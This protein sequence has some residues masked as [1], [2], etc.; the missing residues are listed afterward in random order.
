LAASPSKYFVR[1]TATIQADGHS[2]KEQQYV[3]VHPEKRGT[4][5][6]LFG[7]YDCTQS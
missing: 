4:I 2:W 1:F 6:T 7:L 5:P 3:A